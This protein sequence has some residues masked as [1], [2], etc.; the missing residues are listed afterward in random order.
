M[1]S[2]L[3]STPWF[4]V[5]SYGVMIAVGYSIA[6]LWI[7]RE[8][9]QDGLPG[10][11]VF[12]MLLFQL[13]VGVFGSRFFFMIESGEIFNPSVS[14]FDFERGGLTFYGCGFSSL[15]FDLIFL[16]INNLPYFRVMDCVGMGLPLGIAFSRVGCFLNGCCYGIPC[17]YPWG[18]VFPK[19]SPQTPL[20]PTQLYESLAG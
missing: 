18:V 20:H 10:E 8:A 12:D 11:T 6:T 13:I 2:I 14:F 9:K 7:V 17:D 4:N 1:H 5:Y 15:A 19:I 3:L 16:R